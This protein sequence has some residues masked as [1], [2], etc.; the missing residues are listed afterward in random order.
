M[1]IVIFSNLL[2]GASGLDKSV[3]QTCNTLSKSG[4]DIH[5]INI[6]GK[7]D[8]IFEA[9]PRHFKLS[10][11]V[12][13]YSLKSMFIPRLKNESYIPK[14]NLNQ[15][16]LKARF[17]EKDIKVIKYISQKLS[18]SDLIIFT[19]P[20]Q[21]LLYNMAGGGKAKTLLQIHGNYGEET[22]NLELLN[23]SNNVIDYLQV[24]ASEMIDELTKL[25]RFKKEEILF[26]PNIHIPKKL[27][28]IPKRNEYLNVS[29]IGSIQD[30]KNQVEA[31]R[32]LKFCDDNV[33]LNIWG[34]GGGYFDYIRN[35][36][37]ANELEDRVK[38]HGF[39]TEQEIYQ[40]TDLI[41]MTSR[42]EGFS[43]VLMEAA[44]HGIPAVT[45][46]FLY[47]P[48]E[49]IENGRNGFIV[50][51]GDYQDLALKINLLNRDR[52]LL[53]VFSNNI[54]DKF[55]DNF[56]EDIIVEKYEKELDL[57]KSSIILPQFC[58][59][60]KFEIELQKL[61]KLWVA[62]DSLD[63]VVKI[64]FDNCKFSQESE[65]KIIKTFDNH[66]EK[67]V[68]Y[69][70]CNDNINIYKRDLIEKSRFI[71]HVVYREEWYYI[72][73]TSLKN[74]LEI[75]P[76][77]E[78]NAEPLYGLSHSL[79]EN[80]IL[81][82][83]GA[84]ISIPNGYMLREILDQDG[85]SVNFVMRK[86]SKNSK[87]ESFA[88]IS[89]EFDSLSLKFT[90]GDSIIF[91]RPDINFDDI[92]KALHSLEDECG[93]YLDK[94]NGIYFWELIK[95][96]LFEGL[97]EFC[98]LWSKHF[99][100]NTKLDLNYYGDKCLS[101]VGRYDKVIFEFPRKADVDKK[102]SMFHVDNALVISY[103]QSYGYSPENYDPKS[104]TYPIKDFYD[105]HDCESIELTDK[106]ESI[107]LKLEKELYDRLAIHI[108]AKSFIIARI[109]KFKK[110]YKYFSNLFSKVKP[111]E[112]VVPSAYWSAGIIYA[113][114]ERGIRTSDIQYALITDFH[115][116]YAFKKRKN[117]TADNIYLWD[118]SWVRDSLP[119]DEISIMKRSS[120][121]TKSKPSNNRKIL[122]CS[123]PRVSRR[124]MKNLNSL[125]KCNPNID[126][127]LSLH[128]DEYSTFEVLRSKV[129]NQNI[130]ITCE[131]T[132][133]LLTSVDV[134]IGV[135]STIL[136][137]A[138][139][140]GKKV[141]ILDIPGKEVIMNDSYSDKFTYIRSDSILEF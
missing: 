53:K 45:Y 105:F 1:A 26:I 87:Q 131:D 90:S 104:N 136:F 55:F 77:Y 66:V 37:K 32:A 25:T 4:Y 58:R 107:C 124:L 60:R 83:K 2:K 41:I 95:V 70:I 111:R 59:D 102:T 9:T 139:A 64:R 57:N 23:E 81:T 92:W 67:L 121:V 38:F 7:D 35:Y 20:L 48:R 63:D 5:L 27:R 98:G 135:Y 129:S 69:Y 74:N 91:Y 43:Y 21:S 132:Y 12:K 51:N 112:V 19:H 127:L 128:P 96:S 110:E 93:I 13:L 3:I 14:Y 119:Y 108:D 18:E 137:D 140:M 79:S 11:N 17:N 80:A 116:N 61:S 16:F 114:K 54:K 72:F 94:I 15:K 78:N 115:P 29:I 6:V 97:M 73:N 100:D 141:L 138:L 120:E 76:Y 42:S 39:G 30:R 89:S 130:K 99:S 46:D 71:L 62:M 123:Q 50:N 109:M 133:K 84:E 31:I 24:V 86:R 44:T 85:V 88:I 49:I 125:A 65:L 34:N 33:I 22:H 68:P 106:D 113:A 122:V 101:E 28:V 103:P 36:T 40:S 10:E 56:T 82:D 118:K 134:V 52:E 126:F 8:G 47:G 117:Y 75:L